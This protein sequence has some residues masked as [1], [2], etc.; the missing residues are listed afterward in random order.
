MNR[1][2]QKSVKKCSL[3]DLIRK[4]DEESETD[5]RGSVSRS[6]SGLGSGLGSRSRSGSETGLGS[7]VQGPS[8][9]NK[10]RNIQKSYSADNQS[11]Y[12]NTTEKRDRFGISKGSGA[13]SFTQRSSTLLIQN[14]KKEVEHLKSKLDEQ[15]KLVGK[16]EYALSRKT[17]SCS[18]CSVKDE[19]IGE[20]ES[21]LQDTET[22]LQETWDSM[23]EGSADPVVQFDDIII[24]VHQLNKLISDGFQ[25][26]AGHR[27]GRFNSRPT[28]ELI[29]FQD[30]FI[31]DSSVRKY[32]DQTGHAF[33]QDILDGYFPTELEESFPD[34][35]YIDIID[36]R[37][38][39]LS[40]L[41]FGFQGSGRKLE[42]RPG[43][44]CSSIQEL[45]EPS[46]SSL[47]ISSF[48]SSSAKIYRT[49]S[50]ESKRKKQGNCGLYRDNNNTTRNKRSPKLSS[51]L[52]SNRENLN[53]NGNMKT[54][55]KIIGQTIDPII[56]ELFGEDTIG[57]IKNCLR[58]QFSCKRVH[59]YT[60][61]YFRVHLYTGIY[62]RVHLYT[63]IPEKVKTRGIQTL[64]QLGL[65]PNG[66]L[67]MQV[68]R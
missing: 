7:G 34:G 22:V 17:K 3:T 59:L 43:S 41:Q 40:A 58:E 20:L 49:S 56:L 23:N 62:F 30:F 47:S 1:I 46:N 10:T 42:S 5:L 24:K 9:R 12:L 15:N 37:S 61:I 18:D 64:L 11:G 2:N 27:E 48:S 4:I 21:K 60:G 26:Q 54:K 13:S 50:Q 55:I 57:Y 16:L 52:P 8:S 51:P 53:S 36:R 32:T 65:V 25:M 19:I 33:L 28:V 67:H 29:I 31:L 35:V 14:L 38:D 44:S 66:I 6:G 63:G 39:K 68:L 45:N